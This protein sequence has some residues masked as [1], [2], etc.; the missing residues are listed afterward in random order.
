MKEVTAPVIATTLVLVAVFIPVAAM[1][2]IT[3]MLYQQFAI[4]IAVSVVFSS[5]NALSLSPALCSILMRPAKPMKGPLGAFFRG[6][7]KV[8]DKSAGAYTKRTAIFANKLKRGAVYIL[9]FI[10]AIVLVGRQVPG[11]FIPEEDQGYLFVNIML[12]NASSLQRSDAI[13]EKVEDILGDFDDIDM[14]TNVTGY[15]MIS[16]AFSTNSVFLFI[17]LKDWGERDQTALELARQINGRLHKEINGAMAFAFGPPAIP[18]LGSGSGFTM[19]LQDK[20]GST[21]QFLAEQS[22]KFM[23]AALAREEIGNVFTTYSASVPQRYL[24]IDKDKVLKSGVSLGDLYNTVGAFLGGSYVNDFN[25]FGRLYKTYVQAEPEYRTKPSD[26]G[27]FFVKNKEGTSIP[28]STF[29]NVREIMGPEFTYRFNLYRAAEMSGSPA[30]GYSSAQALSAL[31][32][33]AN[34]VLPPEMGYEWSNMSYQEKK[35]SGSGNIVF[36][37]ALVFVFLILAAQYES[38]SLPMSILLGTPFAVLGAMLF[39]YLGR[40]ISESYVNNVFAQISLVMLIAMAAK[41][42]ILII[43]FASLRFKEGLSLYDAAIRAAKDRFRPIL[44]TAFSFI[45]GVLPLLTASGAGAEARKVMGMALMGGMVIATMLGVFFYPM[46]YV[47]IGKL[48]GYEKKRE[49]AQAQVQAQVVTT[50]NDES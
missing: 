19:M 34:E 28:I 12:P 26:I 16:G 40:F 2:G 37:F 7:N 5:V 18:G 30:P 14:V 27:L 29:V 3:G 44:M 20:S 47:M 25:R 39:L 10:V 48:G 36:V 1:G 32:E 38:W 49:L 46:L 33:V 22:M 35:A 9:I 6:F 21:P 8:F 50:E 24:D 15:S 13:A 41:N 45:L 43:E 17:S 42:A 23:Q 31:E 4:T 11:G